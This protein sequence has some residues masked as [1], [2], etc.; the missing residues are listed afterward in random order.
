L[1][2]FSTGIE[3]SKVFQHVTAYD[4]S[5]K[6]LTAA[7]DNKTKN[8][9][10]F[11][12]DAHVAHLNPVVGGKKFN[13]IV[14]ANLVDRM[15]NPREWIQNSKSI[16]AEDGLL[17]IFSPFTWMKDF[18]KEEHWLGGFRQDSEVVWSLQGA[19]RQAGPELCVCEP[20]SH[21]PFAIPSPDGTIC[22]V[23]SQCVIFGKKGSDRNV[24]LTDVTFSSLSC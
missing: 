22:Y 9:T 1:S 6:F 12:G 15:S 16:L 24:S 3:L 14:G 18:T 13:L 2:P 8:M 11:H 21:V 5:A 17:V 23:Y 19:I 20:P 7:I 10:L 4:Y